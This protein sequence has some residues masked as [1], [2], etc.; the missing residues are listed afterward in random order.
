MLTRRSFITKSASATAGIMLL[1]SYLSSCTGKHTLDKIGYISGIIGK[2]LEGDWKAILKQTVDFGFSEIETGDYLG[3]SAREFLS[4]CKQIGLTPVAG[5]IDFNAGKEDS[6]KRLDALATLNLKYA[7]V[8][9][10]WMVGGPFTLDDCKRSIEQLNIHGENCK[11]HGLI[12]CWHNHDKEFTPMEEGLPFDYLMNHTDKSLVKCEM[13]IFWAMKGGADPVEL[14]EKYKG[15]YAI[16]HVKDMAPGGEK[17]FECP[18]SGIID[19]RSIFRVA[20]A[21]GIE[22]FMVERDNVADGMD[23]LKSSAEFLKNLSF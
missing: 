6:L 1:D 20:K 5:G 17:S 2:E 14:L 15:R 18:G 12:L 19:F 16:L 9:W 23:C 8:Y 22:H 13:D 10:P 3:N 4:Y 21:Q 11:E 7:V